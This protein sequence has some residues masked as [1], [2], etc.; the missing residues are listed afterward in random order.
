[1]RVRPLNEY[2]RAH[3]GGGDG[4]GV[5]TAREDSG[6][7]VFRPAAD[8]PATTY[9]FEKARAP[10]PPS[11]ATQNLPRTEEVPLAASARGR[12]RV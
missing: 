8:G 1:V 6:A 10:S 5:W 12:R 2:E 7:L 11:R 4:D 9:S 3:G